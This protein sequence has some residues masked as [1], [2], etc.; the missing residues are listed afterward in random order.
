MIRNPLSPVRVFSFCLRFAIL[1]YLTF[2]FAPS[3]HTPVATAAPLLAPGPVN[4]DVSNGSGSQPELNAAGTDWESFDTN[5]GVPA[6][7]GI[8][9]LYTPQNLADLNSFPIQTGSASVTLRP[10]TAGPVLNCAFSAAEPVFSSSTADLCFF[11]VTG[12]GDGIQIFYMGQFADGEDIRYT[13][14]GLT[15]AAGGTGTFTNF[16][17]D[18]VVAGTPPSPV[19]GR[20]PAR[21]VLVLD[22]SGSMAWSSH[23]LDPGCNV[24]STPPAGCEPARWEILNDAVN[25]TLVVAKAYA[26]PGDRF[27]AALFDSSVAAAN[28]FAFTTIDPVSVGAFQASLAD[29]SRG[30]GGGTS[31]GA[32]VTTFQADLSSPGAFTQTILLF[33]DGDQNTAPFLVSNA[34]QVL[35]NQTANS[36]VGNIAEFLPGVARL[37]PFALRADNVNGTLGTSYLQDL[38]NKRCEGLM[39]SA[40]SV[41]PTD[42]QLIQFFLQVLNGALIGDKLEMASVQNGRIT[43]GSTPT[44]TVT[45]TTSIDDVSFTMLLNWAERSNGLSNIEMVKDGVVFTL[46]SDIVVGSVPTSPGFALVDEGD[47]YFAV[48]MRQPFCNNAGECV[49]PE[50][51]WA[52]TFEPFFEVGETFTYNAFAIVDN[53]SLASELSVT[54]S[55]PGVQ[56]PLQLQATLTEGGAPLSGLPEGSVVAIV[57][58]PG[59]SLGNVLSQADVNPVGNVQAD[60]ISAAGRKASAMLNDSALRDELLAALQAGLA[61]EVVLT[62]SAPGQ[63]TGTYTDTAVEGIYAINFFVDGETPNNSRFTR[64]FETAYY[65]EVVP[66]PTAIQESAVISPVATCSFAGGCF[67]ISVTPVDSLGNL[68]GPGK[69]PLI[70]LPLGSAAQLIEPVIDHLDGTYQVLVGFPEPIQ[71]NPVISIG[72]VQIRPP[73]IAE[74]PPSDGTPKH[75]QTHRPPRRHSYYD[76]PEFRH[77]GEGHHGGSHRHGSRSHSGSHHRHHR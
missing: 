67:S 41:N 5:Q 11:R 49:D 47:N 25:Q 50:G 20:D 55:S 54:Q 59:A 9:V 51:E 71:E 35:I 19:A 37:C 13:I 27:A 29:P 68:L 72:D 63:Y 15:P 44:E 1:G 46:T 16:D 24:F 45:F 74:S 64:T 61:D 69:D 73:I 57:A 43:Q 36:P 23:P 32:G 76:P 22:K 31:I 52:V 39:N 2:A 62:E 14:S 48:T 4:A 34:T 28:Q 33:T 10:S 42:P 77:Q 66:D 40:V 75:S 3:H 65:V 58:R 60:S 8:I 30:P 7:G 38:A 12:G 18:A 70:F 26:L 21:L 17:S 53:A 6:K 56:Q